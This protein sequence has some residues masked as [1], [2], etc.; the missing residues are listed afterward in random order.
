[1]FDESR[2]VKH[3]LEIQRHSLSA[4]LLLQLL[5]PSSNLSGGSHGVGIGCLENGDLNAFLTVD[6]SDH[7]AFFIAGV[8]RAQVAK[9]DG[10]PVFLGHNNVVDF[11]NILKLVEGSHQILAFALLERSRRQVDVLLAQPGGHFLNGYSQ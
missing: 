2:L 6:P 7:L 1:M 9:T 8:S 3:D 10:H 11:L 4:V 5:Q